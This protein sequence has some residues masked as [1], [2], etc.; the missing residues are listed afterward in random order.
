MTHPMQLE[1][2]R[3]KYLF[4]VLSKDGVGSEAV[5]KIYRATFEEEARLRREQDVIAGRIQHNLR[6]R[7]LIE[8]IVGE[9][10][11]KTEK[12]ANVVVAP[13]TEQ[14]PPPPTSQTPPEHQAVF[15]T[16][17]KYQ[18]E[19]RCDYT[20]GVKYGPDGVCGKKV[21]KGS[22]RCRGCQNK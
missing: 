6:I 20:E 18:A 8:A 16:V 1:L 5:L 10:E 21:A 22:N 17:A 14:Q 2:N 11:P 19:G 12:Q 13:Q 9:L 3:E 15:D 7:T 4:D